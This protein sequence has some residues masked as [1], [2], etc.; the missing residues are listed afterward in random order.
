ME[1]PCFEASAPQRM[2]RTKMAYRKTIDTE[3][4]K[5]ISLEQLTGRED[6]E[7]FRRLINALVKE[8]AHINRDS[9]VTEAEEIKWLRERISATRKGN[10]IFIKA[11]AGG[12]LIGCCTAARGQQTERDNTEL[13]IM[14]DRRWRG[15]GIGRALLGET[16][17]LA[18][19]KWKP[20]NIYLKAV[21]DNRNA[22]V[23][24]TLMGFRVTAVLPGW[25]SDKEGCHDLIV[26]TQKRERKK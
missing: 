9:L 10:E 4:G 2:D 25:I 15:K 16:I 17:R 8:G 7:E 20:R 22:L 24:Y 18:K 13:G 1:D 23:M 3:D 14:L 12:K 19:Q 6:P 5:N 21:K 26:M 11:L